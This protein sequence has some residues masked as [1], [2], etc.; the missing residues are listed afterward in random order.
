[1]IKLF[2]LNENWIVLVVFVNLSVLFIWSV[3]LFIVSLFGLSWW[4]GNWYVWMINLVRIYKNV[5]KYYCENKYVCDFMFYF[6]KCKGSV[7]KIILCKFYLFLW[8]VVLIF[9]V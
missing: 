1:M 2:C 4:F 8:S 3:I 7:K 9:F 5:Y 6:R